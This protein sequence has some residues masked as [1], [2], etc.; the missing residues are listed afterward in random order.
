MM[1]AVLFAI[2]KYGLALYFKYGTP[3]SAFG[4]LGSLAAILIW[5][6]YSAQIVLFGAV[7]TQVFA[8]RR[9][10]GVKPSRHAEFLLECDET[11]TATPSPENPGGKPARP[12]SSGSGRGS[13]GGY[14]A[15]LGR[16]VAS[17]LEAPSHAGGMTPPF[18]ARNLLV[19]GA[20]MALGALIGGYGA[21]QIRQHRTGADPNRLAAQRLDRRI[22]RI[23]RKVAHASRM[24]RYLEQE[25]VNQRLDILSAQIRSS[26]SRRRPVRHPVP[27]AKWSDRML[28]RVKSLF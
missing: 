6:Y 3:T 12:S 20:G 16:H 14:A 18:A 26:A 17:H 5:I 7:F 23:G 27:P 19:A 28:E 2:G 25:D 24:K 21:L 11:E 22:D 13:D 9:G 1:T 4:A 15:V 10:L 8:K